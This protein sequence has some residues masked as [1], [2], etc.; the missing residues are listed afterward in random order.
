MGWHYLLHMD[1]QLPNLHCGWA[2]VRPISPVSED[3]WLLLPQGHVEATVAQVGHWQGTP[4]HI[5][6]CLEDAPVRKLC[7]QHL[8]AVQQ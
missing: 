4:L 2:Q 6:H 7:K 8:A 1:G 3:G 5:L